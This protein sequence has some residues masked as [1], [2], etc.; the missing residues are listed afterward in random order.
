MVSPV[1]TK[2]D[3]DLE[4]ISF[5]SFLC[6][7]VLGNQLWFRALQNNGNNNYYN[8]MRCTALTLYKY[9][10]VVEYLHCFQLFIAEISPEGILVFLLL[11]MGSLDANW[12][13]VIYTLNFN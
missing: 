13:Y 9:P 12:L 5:F 3:M 4:H 1:T 10:S 2:N 8:A 7:F 11:Q 6:L